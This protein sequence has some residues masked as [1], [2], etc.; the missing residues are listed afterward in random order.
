M[1]IK[2]N[3][4]QAMKDFINP[5]DNSSK[6]NKGMQGQPEIK[7]V[8]AYMNDADTA[9]PQTNPAAPADAVAAAP[10]NNIRP[11]QNVSEFA[12][13]NQQPEQNNQPFSQ[14]GQQ[15]FA[16]TNQNSA[17]QFAQNSQQYNQ[18]E[19][20][21]S[22]FGGPF[23][24]PLRDGFGSASDNSSETTVIS[25]NTII[26]GNIRSFADMRIDG[27]IKGNVET[28][29]NVSV[30]GKI[31]GN[32][33]CNNAVMT[34][35]A[36]QGNLTLKG[37]MSMA[38]DS[39]LIGD[40]TSQLASLNGKIKGNLTVSGKAQLDKDSVIFGDIKAGTIS[41]Q[42]GAI[43]QGYVTTTYVTSEESS[44]IFPEKLVIGD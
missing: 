42:D 25:K 19:Q 24:H 28:T 30:N 44:N 1:G 33:T 43:I 7:D 13:N 18:N 41:I 11:E 17:Q 8:A 20:Q 22:S 26:D 9:Q 29:K 5:K 12:Q 38:S 32:I 23:S 31:V 36:V 21:N 14:S 40:L 27:N 35:S 34:S 6:E 16:Q 15:S 37:Q 10:D 3:F 4:S 39:M 2:D